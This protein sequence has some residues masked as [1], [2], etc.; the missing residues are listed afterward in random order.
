MQKHCPQ[1]NWNVPYKVVNWDKL[2]HLTEILD[3]SLFCWVLKSTSLVCILTDCHPVLS[4]GSC[5]VRTNG[6]CTTKCFYSLKIL[7][8]AIF[9]CHPLSSECQTYLQ[10][11]KTIHDFLTALVW[12]FAIQNIQ[13]N[14]WTI[15]YYFC[16]NCFPKRFDDQS[17]SLFTTKC[18]VSHAV[19]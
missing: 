4:E 10:T 6:W 14:I 15:C 2:S 11:N 17:S 9:G 13:V 7:N 19:S 3:Q 12:H 8:Q 18:V 5:F 16:W 1:E